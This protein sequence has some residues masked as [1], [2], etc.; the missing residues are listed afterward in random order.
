LTKI[1]YPGGASSL[2]SYD[3]KSRRTSIIEENS[4]GTVTSTKNYLWI[5]QEMAE[6][7]DAGNNVTKRFFPQG[8]QQSGASYY[9]T[10]D[11]LGSVREMLNSSGIT[12][13]RYAYDPYGKPPAGST[14]NL[15]SGTNLATFQYARMMMHEASGLD[16]ASYRVYKPN[17]GIWSCRDPIA[18]SGGINLYEYGG[19]NPVDLVDPAGLGKWYF[20][21][22][23][24]T[25]IN[26]Y[27]QL[28]AEELKCCKEAV[29]DRYVIWFGFTSPLEDR[30]Y[31]DGSSS[32]GY[33]GGG[34]WDP[35][36]KAQAETDAPGGMS[37][38][39]DPFHGGDG[40]WY[41]APETAVFWYRARCTKGPYAGR[42]LSTA[43]HSFNIPG[44]WYSRTGD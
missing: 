6:E 27:Y 33:T 35:P 17:S 1:S 31:I 7:R 36:D 19:D 42:I 26:V 23:V 37:I 21:A 22:T 32:F 13:A 14:T 9:Y 41:H 2:F 30:D 38:G 39:W 28:D 10:R 12:V 34:S 44:H 18:E 24:T 20:D 25:N 11:H 3:G 43:T 5:G 15:I 29:V 16:L 8:E 4:S 40:N